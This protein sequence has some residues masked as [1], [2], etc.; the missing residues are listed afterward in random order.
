MPVADDVPILAGD[1]YAAVFSYVAV[2]RGADD[3]VVNILLKAFRVVSHLNKSSAVEH[4]A[5]VFAG[6]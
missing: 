3:N 6:N 4:D 1:D 2:A 5:R